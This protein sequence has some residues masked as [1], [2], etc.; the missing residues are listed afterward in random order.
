MLPR[1]GRLG[2][3]RDK[4]DGKPGSS[5]RAAEVSSKTAEALSNKTIAI[6]CSWS[7]ASCWPDLPGSSQS[8]SCPCAALAASACNALAMA[9]GPWVIAMATGAKSNAHSKTRQVARRIASLIHPTAIA[10]HLVAARCLWVHRYSQ[11]I[12][13]HGRFDPKFSQH[14]KWMQSDPPDNG[15]I[16]L[17]LSPP[18]G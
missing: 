4:P 9:S 2:P 14:Q 16:R 5:A 10:R 1:G 15:K 3:S 18:G 6:L 17:N 13:P 12:A 8:W 7:V 11:F